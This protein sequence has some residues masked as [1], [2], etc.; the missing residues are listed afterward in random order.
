MCVRWRSIL[1]TFD[2]SSIIYAWDNYPADQFPPFWD[3]VKSEVQLNHFSIPKIAFEEVEHKAPDCSEWLKDANIR[4]LPVTDAIIQ[5]AMRI[6]TLLEIQEDHY[7]RDGVG[8][9]DLLI[10]ATARSEGLVLISNEA[11]QINLPE[12][13]AK[14]SIPAVCADPQV[15]VDCIDFI[16]LIKQS[17]RVFR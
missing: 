11:R 13:A 5:E 14:K 1:Q 6:K 17:G 7:H 8:E 9:N 2:A 10:I 3:W 4:R 16:T 15:A 12:T